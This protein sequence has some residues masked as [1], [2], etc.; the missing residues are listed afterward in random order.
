MLDKE[1]AAKKQGII[2]IPFVNTSN[3]NINVLYIV[4]QEN[5]KLFKRVKSKNMHKGPMDKDN[6]AGD[7]RIESG[8]WVRG[9][10][11]RGES[12]GKRR[13]TVIAQQLKK[14]LFILLT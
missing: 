12:W 5:Y 7:G 4:S 11:S 6:R 2:Q 9:Q 8:R 13:T 14:C 1:V 3:G 10:V